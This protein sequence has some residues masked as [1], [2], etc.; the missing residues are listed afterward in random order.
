MLNINTENAIH[1][2]S[3]LLKKGELEEAA[4][5]YNN[6][7]EKFPNNLRAQKGL[8]QLYEKKTLTLNLSHLKNKYINFQIFITIKNFLKR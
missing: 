8:A 3:K 4:K 5:V 1:K 2:A 7:L 6:L